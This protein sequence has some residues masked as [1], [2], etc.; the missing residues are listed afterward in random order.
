MESILS[1]SYLK[2]CQIYTNSERMIRN[3]NN[4]ELT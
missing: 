3:I 1:L 2:D 4:F